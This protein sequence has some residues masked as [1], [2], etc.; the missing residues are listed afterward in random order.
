MANVRRR[1]TK[2]NLR[3]RLAILKFAASAIDLRKELSRHDLAAAP[4]LIIAFNS[5][6]AVLVE[7][8]W[9]S[10]DAQQKMAGQT[11]RR[12]RHPSQTYP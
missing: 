10:D 6:D 3:R 9:S 5:L 1:K 4:S 8:G 11:I 7:M 2:A 12:R